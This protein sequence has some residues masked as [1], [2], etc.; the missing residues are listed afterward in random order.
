M[1]QQFN[2]GQEIVSQ[3]FND[4]QSRGERFLLDQIIYELL[5][6]KSD[7]FFQNAMSAVLSKLNFSFN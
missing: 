6:K 5:Q 3:D 1:R 4:L 2:V 7:G